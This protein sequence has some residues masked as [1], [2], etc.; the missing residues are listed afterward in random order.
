VK[1]AANKAAHRLAKMALFICE[2]EIMERG[3]PFVCL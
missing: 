1:R 2:K 3:L